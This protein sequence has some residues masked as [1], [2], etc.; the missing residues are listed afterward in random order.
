MADVSQLDRVLDLLDTGLQSTTEPSFGSDHD[1]EDCARCQRRPTIDTGDLCASCRAFLVGAS[2]DDPVNGGVAPASDIVDPDAANRRAEAVAET[3][4]SFERAL[5]QCTRRVV[6]AS[7][8]VASLA[9]LEPGELGRVTSVGS[10]PGGA[11]PGLEDG[12]SPLAWLLTRLAREAQQV[13]HGEAAGLVGG[14]RGNPRR[15]CM[16]E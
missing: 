11:G 10:V 7:G 14:Q 16:E 6:F 1:P 15:R 5:R 2:D 3:T 9:R 12:D 13:D 8:L 4:E